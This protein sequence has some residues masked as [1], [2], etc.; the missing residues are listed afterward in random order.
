MTDLDLHGWRNQV[1]ALQ[2]QQQARLKCTIHLQIHEQLQF[3]HLKSPIITTLQH[4][5]FLLCWMF[6]IVDNSHLQ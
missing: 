5:V 2:F 1:Y 3:S 6:P 4:D